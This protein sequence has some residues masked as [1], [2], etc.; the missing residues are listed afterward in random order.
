MTLGDSF[1]HSGIQ[2]HVLHCDTDLVVCES[3]VSINI[4]VLFLNDICVLL[5]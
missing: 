5:S 2:P 4:A 1:L 3:F